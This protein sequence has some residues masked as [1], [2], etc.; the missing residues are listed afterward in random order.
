M[1]RAIDVDGDGV[2]SKAEVTSSA[3]ALNAL[4]SNRD[5]QIDVGEILS[6]VE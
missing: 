6:K 2:L 4:D 1:I 5:G 3:E